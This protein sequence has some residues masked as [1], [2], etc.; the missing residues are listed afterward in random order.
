MIRLNVQNKLQYTFGGKFFVFGHFYPNTGINQSELANKSRYFIANDPYFQYRCDY[1]KQGLS[2]RG[3]DMKDRE[4][5]LKIKKQEIHYIRSSQEEKKEDMKQTHKNTGG[6]ARGGRGGKTLRRGAYMRFIMGENRLHWPP[7]YWSPR[8]GLNTS[9]LYLTTGEW[10][11]VPTVELIGIKPLIALKSQLVCQWK[12]PWAS[13]PWWP[14]QQSLVTVAT[15][16]ASEVCIKLGR[17][18]VVEEAT[19]IQDGLRVITLSLLHQ[20]SLWIHS[21]NRLPEGRTLSHFKAHRK[22]KNTINKQEFGTGSSRKILLFLLLNFN[23]VSFNLC[24]LTVR[25]IYTNYTVKH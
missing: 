13:C 3:W 12:V 7:C 10:N 14:P 21:R 9:I 24:D 6:G 11:S 15:Q 16:T 4:V 18:R 25:P 17:P 8:A 2:G 5:T 20:E 23:A 1:A 22:N 19:N